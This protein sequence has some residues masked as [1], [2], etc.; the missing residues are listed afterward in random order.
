MN[1]ENTVTFVTGFGRKGEEI[2]LQDKKVLLDKGQIIKDK[3]YRIED[4]CPGSPL[5]TAL[6]KRKR[7]FQWKDAT[8][9]VLMPCENHPDI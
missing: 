2:E 5:G 8:S 1:K 4:G 6:L 9:F 3:A 7:E